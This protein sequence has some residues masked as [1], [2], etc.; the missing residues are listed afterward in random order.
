MPA[1]IDSAPSCV[2]SP[3][4]IVEGDD[5]DFVL[6]AAYEKCAGIMTFGPGS[7]YGEDGMGATTQYYI[8]VILGM[9]VM[10][11]AWVAWIAFEHHDLKQHDHRLANGR[12]LTDLPPLDPPLAPPR[13]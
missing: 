11:A 12:Q 2:T 10:V 4:G 5:A 9:V 1:I 13:T 8:L 3:G 7:T 6:N